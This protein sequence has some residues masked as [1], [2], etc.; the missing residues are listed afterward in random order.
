M[1]SKRLAESFLQKKRFSKILPLISGNSILDF[2]GNRG[3]LKKHLRNSQDYTL[4]NRDYS[5]LKGKTFDTILSLAVIEHLEIADVFKVI[6]MLKQ[7]LNPNGII[8]LT[9]P[10][11]LAKPV[12]E[13]MSISGLLDKENLKEHKHYWNKRE[14]FE[15]AKKSELNV[16]KYLKFQF[17]LNQLIVLKK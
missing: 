10:S 14:L 16:R 5:V 13:V 15:L 17:G 12:L 3:E 1:E 4:C 7:H 2:G 8:I 11:K 6:K 9:T